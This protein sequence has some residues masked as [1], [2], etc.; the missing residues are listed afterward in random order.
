MGSEPEWMKG[1]TLAYQY[2]DF[3][4]ENFNEVQSKLYAI[5]TYERDLLR[6]DIRKLDYCL[7]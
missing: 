2:K 4:K 1:Q 7:K 5:I 6:T 3:D